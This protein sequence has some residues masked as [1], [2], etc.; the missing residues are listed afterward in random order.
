MLFQ[1]FVD[2][3]SAVK[4][5][6]YQKYV[7]A[8]ARR[9]L[10]EFVQSFLDAGTPPPQVPKLTR[11]WLWRWKLDYGVS[12][13]APNRRYKVSYQGLLLR[14]N[15]CW[16]NNV[17]VRHFARRILGV[18]PGDHLDN[19]DQKGWHHNQAGSKNR[20]SL[21]FKGQ[22]EVDLKENHTDTRARLSFFTYC[23]NNPERIARG[24]PAEICFKLDGPGSTVLPRLVLPRG[25]FSVRCSDSGSYRE[26][27]VYLFLELALEPAS[28]DRKKAKDWRMFYLD[29]YSAHLSYRIFALCWS[30]MYILLFHGGGC[31][32]LTQ[33]NDLW[34]HLEVE[35]LLGDLEGLE[36]T[37]LALM[38]EHKVPTISR[39]SIVTNFFGIWTDGIDHTRS[40]A[41]TKRAGLSIALDGSE[42]QKLRRFRL[43]STPPAPSPST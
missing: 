30:R 17:C 40:I 6:I 36:F 20:G 27:H 42:D 37:R 3:K 7:L 35:Q 29:I 28:E 24:L 41:W 32:G 21:H 23:S 34:L 16:T 38:R 18:D 2:I 43:L 33:T 11:L 10:S 1:W 13:R 19:A 8:N 9:L 22:D 5:R 14:L 26:E 12:F 31:T 25:P 39:Q 4:V 15:I